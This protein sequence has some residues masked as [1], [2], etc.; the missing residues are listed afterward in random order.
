MKFECGK[1]DNIFEV[2]GIKESVVTCSK[3]GSRNSIVESNESA[4]DMSE[5]AK[6][7]TIELFGNRLSRDRL[8]AKI[9]ATWPDGVTYRGKEVIDEYLNK[10]LPK[11]AKRFGDS[12]EVYLGYNRGVDT[13]LIGFDVFGKRRAAAAVVEFTVSSTGVIKVVDTF[14]PDSSSIGRSFYATGGRYNGLRLTHQGLIDLR[15][16]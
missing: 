8:E 10:W 4:T 6:G 15:L 7:D 11:F 2:S 13:F 9:S 16:D 5:E 14:S 12:Q 3:C 1:C